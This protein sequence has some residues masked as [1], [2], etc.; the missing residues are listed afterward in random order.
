MQEILLVK[1]Y[2]ESGLWK[3]FKKVNFTF[4]FQTQSLLVDKVFK[5]KRDM[6]LVTSRSSGYK[7]SSQKFFY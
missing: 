3:L 1:R 6:E 2:L 5:N 4:F 7:R